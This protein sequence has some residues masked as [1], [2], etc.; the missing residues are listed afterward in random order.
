[1]NSLIDKYNIPGPRYTSYPTVPYWDDASFDKEKWK[2]SVIRS[3]NVLKKEQRSGGNFHL[4]A[5]AVLRATVHFLRLPQTDHQAALCG[6]A[7]Y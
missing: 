2:Q 4:Y 1:M 3:Y 6:A 5:P 7:V